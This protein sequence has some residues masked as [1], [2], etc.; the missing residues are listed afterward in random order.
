MSDYPKTLH[1][2]GG[3]FSTRYEGVRVKY[4]VVTAVDEDHEK[5]LKKEG[6][7]P[8]LKEALEA[9]TTK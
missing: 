4:S 2:E 9:K 3:I 8:G 5:K 6:W 1:K 7:K